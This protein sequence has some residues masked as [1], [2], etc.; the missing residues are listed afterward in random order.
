LRLLGAKELF[1]VAEGVFHC[2]AV[3]KPD[4][5]AGW[6]HF[7]ISGEVKGFLLFLFLVA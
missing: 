5:K 3:S 1:D 6:L 4:Y 7:D 2:P